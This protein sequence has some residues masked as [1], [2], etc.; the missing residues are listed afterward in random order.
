METKKLSDSI[1]LVNI[2]NESQV[3]EAIRKVLDMVSENAD[4]DFVIHFPFVGNINSQSITNLLILHKTLGSSGR[5]L[6]LS[7][8]S[9]ATRKVFSVIGLDTFFEITD[10]YHTT[11][12]KLQKTN[13]NPD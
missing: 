1:V 9:P 8:V 10:D 7:S 13:Q 12:S 3:D 2:G 4:R 5:R 6:I 11:L